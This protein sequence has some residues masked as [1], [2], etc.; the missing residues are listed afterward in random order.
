M[1]LQPKRGRGMPNNDELA[2]KERG[3]YPIVFVDWV[4]SC[5]QLD[6]AGRNS[7]INLYDLPEPQR[8]FQSGFLIHND[9]DYIVVAGGMKPELETFDYVISIPRVAIHIIRYL[10]ITK[11]NVGIS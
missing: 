3:G 1:W 11:E 5:E 4:D 2:A 7:E 8:I 9:P 6:A 10:E